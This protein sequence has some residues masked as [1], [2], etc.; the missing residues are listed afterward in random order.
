MCRKSRFG[1]IIFIFVLLLNGKLASA[2]ESSYFCSDAAAPQRLSNQ[3]I[4]E[5][6]KKIQRKDLTKLVEQIRIEKALT[7]L[8]LD[9]KI[10]DPIR[11]TNRSLFLKNY[12]EAI[13]EVTKIS[14]I[15]DFFNFENERLEKRKN[16]RIGFLDLNLKPINDGLGKGTG[17]IVIALSKL[18]TAGIC[19][20]DRLLNTESRACCDK[21]TKTSFKS[22]AFNIRD[23]S[24]CELNAEVWRKNFKNI[25]LWLIDNSAPDDKNTKITDH[26]QSTKINILDAVCRGKT[27]FDIS[28]SFAN[29]LLKSKIPTIELDKAKGSLHSA[30]NKRITQAQGLVNSLRQKK[31]IFKKPDS[32]LLIDF[33]IIAAI[34]KYVSAEKK[35]SEQKNIARNAGPS[36]K[37]KES[38]KLQAKQE[39]FQKT[40][41]KVDK[42]L[43]EDT[44]VRRLK[45]IYNL[46]NPLE[47][48]FYIRADLDPNIW[49]QMAARG[50]LIRR[51]FE[52]IRASSAQESDFYFV[53]QGSYKVLTEMDLASEVK[54]L[55]ELSYDLYSKIYSKKRR[56]NNWR[57]L[58]QIVALSIDI[59]GAGAKDFAQRLEYWL[60][61]ELKKLTLA[62][63]IDGALKKQREIDK[64]FW[65]VHQLVKNRITELC[66]TLGCQNSNFI[67]ATGDDVTVYMSFDKK[68]DPD[69][70]SKLI[71][72]I[73][74]C[75]KTYLASLNDPIELRASL[76]RSEYEANA[77]ATLSEFVQDFIPQFTKLIDINDGV[78]GGQVK[79]QESSP[80][81]NNKRIEFI[82]NVFVEDLTQPKPV[83]EVGFENI[84]MDCKA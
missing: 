24:G 47:V 15:N 53:K 55:G 61:P 44:D 56:R 27:K 46:I 11:T 41:Q 39:D 35:Y 72:A 7:W 70:T 20:S 83:P 5:F 71:S 67:W 22:F 73:K 60:Q 49:D 8:R 31:A 66:I 51:S 6:W 50:S 16:N 25:T 19:E 9:S 2:N 30:L 17:D 58:N 75:I 34:R 13:D 79:K 69:A 77:S 18:A 28:T 14:L 62:E 48:P 38:K 64:G 65:T 1:K 43:P 74:T 52:R 37:A 32:P 40:R 10:D 3:K 59:K 4:D 42:L 29:A 26:P 57:N 76:I 45:H 82:G 23:I 80:C 36:S 63:K 81:N 33:D 84:E 12:G 21:L 78:I 68:L 54:F